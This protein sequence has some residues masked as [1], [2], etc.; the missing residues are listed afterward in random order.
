M[1]KQYK[2]K[3]PAV[4]STMSTFEQ[5]F[6]AKLSKSIQYLRINEGIIKE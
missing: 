1:F 6:R 2:L 4:R 5:L 3:S